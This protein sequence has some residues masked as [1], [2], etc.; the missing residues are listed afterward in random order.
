MVGYFN[1]HKKTKVE[2]LIRHN[3]LRFIVHGFRIQ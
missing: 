3:I 1:F 2:L